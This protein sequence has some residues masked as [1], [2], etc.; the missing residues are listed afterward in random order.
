ME[1]N[2][3]IA[4]SL[5]VF[6][7]HCP[8]ID[9]DSVAKVEK[10]GRVI[11]SYKYASLSNILNKIKPV[12]ERAGLVV[13]HAMNENKI[14]TEIMHVETGE[15]KIS[16]CDIPK[17]TSAQQLGAWITYMRRYQLVMLL[18]LNCDED[19]DGRAAGSPSDEVDIKE[20]VAHAIKHIEALNS[21]DEINGYWQ[22][23]KKEYGKQAEVYNA[24]IKAGRKLQ[25][26]E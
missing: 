1:N 16:L 25:N 20:V 5:A 13:L 24:A 4:K 15:R 18:N 12:L 6:A 9:L 11:Y 17:Q 21:I 19:V 22:K 3:A 2:N 10:N 26:N 8:K 7:K 14:Y 23:F